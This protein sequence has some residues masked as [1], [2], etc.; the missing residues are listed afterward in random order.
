MI[1][2]KLP[3]KILATLMILCCLGVIWGSIIFYENTYAMQENELYARGTSSDLIDTPAEAKEYVR[4]KFSG[5]K[6]LQVYMSSYKCVRSINLSQNLLNQY[7]NGIHNTKYDGTCSEVAATILTVMYANSDNPDPYTT[8]SEILDYAL[9]NGYYEAG[10]GTRRADSDCITNYGLDLYPSSR[11]KDASN[12]YWNVYDVLKSNAKNN[13]LTMFNIKDHS[14]VGAGYYE[15]KATW[16][17]EKSV[18]WFS[19]T[20]YKEEIVRFAIVNQGW[21]ETHPYGSVITTRDFGRKETY[22]LFPADLIG[23]EFFDS[24][25][26]KSSYYNVV[27]E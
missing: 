3:I 7:Y 18:L 14:M 5:K 10:K 19:W 9:E 15:L 16:Q 23:S 26:L 8:F 6:N 12:D 21:A 22:Q 24:L 17:E 2:L 13:K 27:I 4:N 20:E 1:K 25:F 11:P